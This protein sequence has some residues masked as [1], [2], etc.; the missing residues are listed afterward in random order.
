MKC[1]S[2]LLFLLV[3]VS[4][5]QKIVAQSSVAT[6]AVTTGTSGTATAGTS[7]TVNTL[8]S[9]GTSGTPTFATETTGTTVAVT[10]DTTTVSEVTTSGSDGVVCYVCDESVDSDCASDLATI[11]NPGNYNETCL[12]NCWTIIDSDG[13]IVRSCN[14]SYVGDG[15]ELSCDAASETVC[16]ETSSVTECYYCCSDNYCNNEVISAGSTKI[17]VEGTNLFAALL[18]STI[19]YA[20]H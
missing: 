10:Q 9:A 19:L 5:T 1:I 3:L 16:M 13:Y 17:V 8:A 14:D 2:S 7:G 20:L 4:V 15:L 6:T 18:F 12:Y 11:S